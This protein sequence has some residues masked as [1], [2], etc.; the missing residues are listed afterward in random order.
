MIKILLT[1]MLQIYS[2]QNVLVEAH[3]AC[4]NNMKITYKIEQKIVCI[5]SQVTGTD[6]IF[7]NGFE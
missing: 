4:R 7:E 5:P 3:P 2:N 1:A 6:I